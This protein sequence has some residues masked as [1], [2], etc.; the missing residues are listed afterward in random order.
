MTAVC[1]AYSFWGSLIMHLIGLDGF[2]LSR[3]EISNSLM[4]QV[5]SFV[6]VSAHLASSARC[7]GVCKWQHI[8]CIP[9]ILLNGCI[10]AF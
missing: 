7:F 9:K 6:G 3:K 5:K 10:I 1:T 2:L 8:S 4:I